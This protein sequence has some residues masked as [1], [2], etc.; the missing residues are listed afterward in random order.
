MTADLVRLDGERQVVRGASAERAPLWATW[1]RNEA[2]D[3]H[4]WPCL[5]PD[6][7]AWA[8]L[9]VPRGG[10]DARVAVSARDGV[11]Q[12]SERLDGIPIYLQWSPGGRAVAVLTH[13]SEG[14]GLQVVRAGAERVET[15]LTGTPLFFTWLD[16]ERIVAHVGR[17]VGRP[18]V[19]VVQGSVVRPF[20]G[21]PGSFCTPV[22]TR[23]GVV[24]SAVHGGHE[25]L[26]VTAP[27]GLPSRELERVDGLLALV[28]TPAGQVLRAISSD[29][30]GQA[31]HDLRSLDPRTGRTSRLA[32]GPLLAFLP[33]PD[34]AV[35]VARR[36]E[37][38]GSFSFSRISADG[39]DE[40]L[41][42]EVLPSRDLRFWVRFFEQFAASHPLVDPTGRSLV[43][44][45]R[46][47]D[48]DPDRPRIWRFPLD[49]GPAEDLGEGPFAC[50]APAPPTTRAAQEEGC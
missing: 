35:V 10:G 43:L 50:F 38:R 29:G 3:V 19:L 2:P 8:A 4:S 30:D 28:P 5:S 25:S 24:W 39:R 18:E 33:V 23:A 42:G 31:Y 34:G 26:L 27:S 6:G 15:W 1:G 9:R 41:I 49:G 45:G 22:V 36:N 40:R 13:R 44:A 37:R 16:D 21:Q 48:T 47:T 17:E 14:L 20:P 12:E 32:D 46:R 7:R 11:E